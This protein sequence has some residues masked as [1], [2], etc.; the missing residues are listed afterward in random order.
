MRKASQGDV[1]LKN[2]RNNKGH[3][4]ANSMASEPGNKHTTGYAPVLP[5]LDLPPRLDGP[6]DMSWL[7]DDSLSGLGRK[8]SLPRIKSSSSI[9]LSLARTM[10]LHTDDHDPKRKRYTCTI[11]QDGMTQPFQLP[12]S[13]GTTGSSCMPRLFQGSSHSQ[14]SD[15]EGDTNSW[16][17]F[18]GLVDVLDME[19]TPICDLVHHPMVVSQTSLSQHSYAASVETGLE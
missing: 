16:G 15:E 4:P 14:T 12:M 3:P 7:T 2:A 11:T 19:C 5:E 18:E 17:S 10:P 13:P 8:M 9:P 1:T 6:S